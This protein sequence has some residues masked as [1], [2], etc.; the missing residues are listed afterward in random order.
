MICTHQGTSETALGGSAFT[1][2]LCKLLPSITANGLTNLG[3]A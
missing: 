1:D 2:V 3:K